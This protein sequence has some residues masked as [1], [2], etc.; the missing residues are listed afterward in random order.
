MLFL[1]FIFNV[2]KK[3]AVGVIEESPKAE[4]NKLLAK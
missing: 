3:I 1:I 2:V 4:I